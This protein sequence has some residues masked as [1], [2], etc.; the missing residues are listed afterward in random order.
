MSTDMNSKVHCRCSW[1]PVNDPIYQEYHDTEWG[2]PEY[3]SK[4]LFAKLLLDGAQAGLSWRTILIKRDAYYDLFA[5]L[6][7]VKLAKFSD[8][9]LEKILL[10]PAIVR[11]RLKVYGFRQNA[12]AFLKLEKNGTDFSELL[13][14]FVG[15]EPIVNRWK[16]HKQYPTETK[17]S[18]AM[19]KFL[20]KAGFTFVGST[21]CYAFMQACGLVNDHQI[22][23]FRHR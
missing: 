17:E 3:D 5:N 21:I 4:A 6:D 7:P 9:R 22:D 18:Q 19:S 13:W 11:N 2:V 15:G 8:A 10:N 23:C 20:K 16:N 12:R 1:V 14:S